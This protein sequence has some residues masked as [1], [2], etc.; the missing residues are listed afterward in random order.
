VRL[1]TGVDAVQ[2]HQLILTQRMR[3]SL[4]VLQ[5]PVPEL[6]ALVQE[7]LLGNP[8]LEIEPDSLL[9]SSGE[10]APGPEPDDDGAGHLPED[11]AAVATAARP[12]DDER[13]V[14]RLPDAGGSWRER[15]LGQLRARTAARGEERIAEELLGSVDGRGYLAVPVSELAASLGVDASRV[16]RVRRRLMELDPP[17]IGALDLS[18]CLTAQLRQAGE[19]DSLAARIVARDLERIARRRLEEVAVRHGVSVAA[20]RRAVQRIRGLSP[21]PAAHGIGDA[22]P[23]VF[24]D[25]VVEDVAGSLEVFPC[26]RGLPQVRIVPPGADLLRRGDARTRAFVA[27][28][29]AQ[30]RW[31]VGSLSARQRTLVRLMRLVVR[32][33]GAYFRRGAAGLRPLGYR[34]L[35]GPMGLHES[36]VARAVRGKHVQ[37]PRGVVPLR[38]FFSAALAGADGEPRAAASVAARIRELVDHER[39]AAPLSD[40]ALTRRLQA[41]G[42]RIARRTVAKYRERLGIPRARYRKP[43]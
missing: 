41:E 4:A 33:Q 35:A 16:E 34:D 7:A 40:E 2:R 10:G 25:L 28:R 43:I 8:F 22:A 26:D 24:P 38:C 14:E 1:R 17:G 27:E 6:A 19:G 11:R 36:T 32:A 3:L 29:L 30:A 5:A 15:V 39:R 20:V 9:E 21:H 23:P 37:T 42:L 31:L 12:W 18:D 13:W